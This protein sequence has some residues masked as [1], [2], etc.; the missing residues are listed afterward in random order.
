MWRVH[1]AERG[2]EAAAAASAAEASDLALAALAAE[3]DAQAK[4]GIALRAQ[5]STLTAEV[6]ATR[7]RMPKIENLIERVQ[8][9]EATKARVAELEAERDAARVEVGGA[10]AAREAE[11]DRLR[12]Q[13]SAAEDRAATAAAQLAE[14]SGASEELDD[15]REAVARLEK[16]LE[17]ER[18][19]QAKMDASRE[20]RVKECEGYT[21]AARSDL[22]AQKEKLRDSEDEVTAL[23]AEVAEK[24]E[25]LERMASDALK[26]EAARDD[27]YNDSFEE[28]ARARVSALLSSLSLSA[29]GRS[30][31]AIVCACALA[32]AAALPL[33]RTNP[34]LALALTHVA[35]SRAPPPASPPSVFLP[36]SVHT[37]ALARLPPCTRCRAAVMR[38]EFDRMKRTYENRLK[39]AK[40]ELSREKRDRRVEL[41]K[42]QKELE[43]IESKRNFESRRYLAL[44]NT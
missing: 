25:E 44:L 2:S 4:E 14:S 24:E 26:R 34:S 15:A 16:Q 18:A 43:S 11:L 8:M 35:T 21:A 22:R 42:V 31:F 3:R 13:C 30:P 19:A 27:N 10:V 9:L 17:R 12:A 32:G 40:D 36:P 41:R 28:G 38:D 33:P 37:V 39:T 6:E 20:R 29:R 1:V 5:L 23:T 7:A